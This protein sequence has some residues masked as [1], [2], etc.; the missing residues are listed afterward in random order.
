ME[1][2]SIPVFLPGK[3]YRHKSRGEWVG[4]W[5]WVWVWVWVCVTN[6]MLDENIFKFIR[7]VC[8][9]DLDLNIEHIM[10]NI[11]IYMGHITCT[12][13]IH[14]GLPKQLD[15]YILGLKCFH[16]NILQSFLI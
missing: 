4:V 16:L 15:K 3:S 9:Y 5:V 1:T 11:H 10:K 7:A 2:H 6:Q 12:L 13:V 14:T 8:S